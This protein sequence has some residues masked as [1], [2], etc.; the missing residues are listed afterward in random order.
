[1]M[2]ELKL[3]DFDAIAFDV[4]GTLANTVPTH[5]STR[6]EAFHRHGF[7]HITRDQH[8]LGST[9]GSSHFDILGGIL[10]AAGEIDASVPFHQNQIVLDVIET[11]SSLFRAAAA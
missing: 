1:F 8:E 3:A 6:I 4:E 9:Y 11:K 2:K 5:H 10:H 7:G